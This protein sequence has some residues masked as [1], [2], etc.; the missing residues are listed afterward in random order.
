MHDDGRCPECAKGN[1]F[2]DATFDEDGHRIRWTMWSC[3]HC[4]RSVLER[5]ARSGAGLVASND[6]E[7]RLH[8][9]S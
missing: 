3:G 9:V 1:T 8:T 5:D 2:S 4:V 6:V 7:S